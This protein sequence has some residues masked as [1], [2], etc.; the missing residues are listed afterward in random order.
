GL[1]LPAAAQQKKAPDP[2]AAPGVVKSGKKVKLRLYGQITREFGFVQDG[3]TSTFKQGP[4]GNT[5]TRM[6]IDGRGKITKDINLR[7]RLEF[8]LNS[9]EAGGGDQF[10]N[11]AG[12]NDFDIRHLD[13]IVSH[14]R[15]GAVYVGRGDSATNGVVEVTLAP[16]MNTGRLGGSVHNVI[17]EYRLLD[18][19]LE[20]SAIGTVDR[21]FNSFD[22][23]GRQNR[24][25]YDTPTFFGFKASVGLI[26]K[27][28][29]D[30][31]LRYSGKVLGT[32]I[33][34]AVGWCHTKG[35]ETAGDSGCFGNTDGQDGGPDM[36]GTIEGV[37]QLSGSIS[38]LT[39]IGLGATFAGG[40]QWRNR[41]DVDPQTIGDPIN[42]VPSIFYTTKVTELGATTVEYAY[43]YTEDIGL[44]GDEG[45]GHAVTLVQK[46]DSVGGDYFLGFR[47]VDVETSTNQNIDALWWVGGGFRQRF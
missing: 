6:G 34:G 27:H 4:N 45:R 21:F 43:Q 23:A 47:Y 1:A 38:A 29:V 37:T 2:S 46:V 41:T 3:E 16:G 24:I 15:Y 8:A 44:K 42:L 13:V 40:T 32:Q 26:D 7:T 12:E 19:S 10:E 39:P 33:R 9:G 31:A 18:T 28:N 14:K 20:P 5:S 17:G 25:R 22:G 30:A 36:D 35:T 11:Q